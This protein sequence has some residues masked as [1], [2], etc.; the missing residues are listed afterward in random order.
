MLKVLLMR[1]IHWPLGSLWPSN[2]TFPV[3]C[4]SWPGNVYTPGAKV[5]PPSSA[6]WRAA[7]GCCTR[8]LLYAVMQVASALHPIVLFIE[9][10]LL[11]FPGGKPYIFFPGQVPQSPVI[12]VGPVLFRLVPATAPNVLARSRSTMKLRF[13]TLAWT[14][15]KL[16]RAERASFPMLEVTSRI[17]IGRFKESKELVWI[18]GSE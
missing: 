1:K 8:A 10:I 15:L 13:S 17:V 6:A 18:A 5:R 9:D 14:R 12:D 16:M 2:V 3:N 7:V 4:A 11:H